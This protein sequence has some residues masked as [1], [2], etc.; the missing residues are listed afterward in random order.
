MTHSAARQARACDC[1]ASRWCLAFVYWIATRTPSTATNA[2]VAV[3]T[4]DRAEKRLA[5]LRTALATVDGK[6][7]VLKQAAAELADRE[8]GL[9]PGDTA[10]QAQAQL[11]EILGRIAEAADSAHRNP[12]GRVRAAPS[13]RRR[14]R[15]SVGRRDHRMPH[16]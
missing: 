11:L 1:W 16:R 2:A 5:T 3:D 6:E 8:K 7:A 9:I 12:A 4:V 14:L 10:N 15:R 13:L